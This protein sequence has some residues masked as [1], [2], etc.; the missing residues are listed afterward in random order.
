M[1]I[2]INFSR[3]KHRGVHDVIQS[4]LDGNI[5]EEVQDLVGMLNVGRYSFLLPPFGGLG[6]DILPIIPFLCLCL[7]RFFAVRVDGGGIRDG[8][9]RGSDWDRCV[10]DW[11]SPLPWSRP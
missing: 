2:G 1:R 10:G 6:D 3:F 7:E 8:L 4:K 11:R 5:L 9:G